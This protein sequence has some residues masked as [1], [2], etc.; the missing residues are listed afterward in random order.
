MIQKA[1][2]EGDYPYHIHHKDNGY[3]ISNTRHSGSHTNYD[4]QIR[5]QLDEWIQNNPEASPSQAKDALIWFQQRLREELDN[6]PNV[7]VDN[8]NVPRFE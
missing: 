8:L 7:S 2:S 6:S 5:G 3:G 1:A 4:N